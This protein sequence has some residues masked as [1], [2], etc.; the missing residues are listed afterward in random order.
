MAHRIVILVHNGVEFTRGCVPTLLAQDIGDV[1]LTIV[2]NAPDQ[3]TQEYLINVP[4]VTRYIAQV[5]V[6]KAW[7]DA[8]KAAW[9]AGENHVLVV[10]NDIILRPDTYRYLY[11]S[12]HPLVFSEGVSSHEEMHASAPSKL[13]PTKYDFSCFL[14]TRECWDRVGPF[15]EGFGR[16]FYEDDDYAVRAWRVGIR[17]GFIGV[18]HRHYM[19]GTLKVATS[20]QQAA[21]RH[22]SHLNMQRFVSKYGCVPT[23]SGTREPTPEFVALLAKSEFGKAMP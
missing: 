5:S 2:A 22:Q 18:K 9:D 3:A 4:N 15:D 16:A 19:S 12:Q 13:A 7:N 10:N 8:I 6:T 20:E 23:L 17:F 14:M 21:M 1:H 11:V